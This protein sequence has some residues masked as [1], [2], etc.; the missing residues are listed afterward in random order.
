MTGGRKRPYA[1]EMDAYEGARTGGGRARPK[2][3]GGLGAWGGLSPSPP[4]P[5][6]GAP[7][8]TLLLKRRRGWKAGLLP[9]SLL[10]KRRR[11]WKAG[12]PPE[13]LLLSAGGAGRRGFRPRPRGPGAEPLCPGL[14]STVC[15][16]I[17]AG[18]AHAAE[19]HIDTA[20]RPF[21]APQSV[22]CPIASLRRSRNQ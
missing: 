2:P 19:P 6:T 21:G 7:P 4:L 9:E 3:H 20:P 16:A 8:Q 11:G 1:P 22:Q 5:T 14:P 15:A 17:V 13:S 12:L 18:R 10:L